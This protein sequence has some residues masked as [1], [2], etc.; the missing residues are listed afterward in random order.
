[1]ITLSGPEAKPLSGGKAKQLIVFLHGVGADGNDLFGLRQPF[2]QA[3]P[4]AHIASPNAPFDCDMAP[5]GYQWFSLQDRSAPAMLQG[6][7][8]V[9]PIV[10]QFLD[11]KLQTL[12]ITNNALAIVGFSQG[13][14]TALHT[15]LRRDAACGAVLGYSGAMI[16]SRSLN[17]DIKSRPPVCLVH[18]DSDMV[19]PYASMVDA[20]ATLTMNDVPHETH[21]RPN[22]GHG[23]DPKG[24]EIGQAFLKKHLG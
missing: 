1:M 10:S 24:V 21:T 9:A 22:L 12:G 13:T 15:M 16:S 8:T 4:D 20:E 23:I 19:V 17:S 2:Q 14:M 7:Q 3:F 5:Y 11:S 6:V 18:G